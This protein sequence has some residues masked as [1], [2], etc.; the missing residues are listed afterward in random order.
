MSINVSQ[1]QVDQILHTHN[2]LW[3]ALYDRDS[4]DHFL[5]YNEKK[6]Q[7]FH[8]AHR[9]YSSVILPNAAGNTFLWI[10]Q[11]LNKSTY[12]THEIHNGRDKNQDIRITWVVDTRH[13]QFSYRS[14]IKTY[15]DLAGNLISGDIEYYTSFGTQVIWSTN[16]LYLTQK[17]KH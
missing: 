17:S 12:G 8:P 10:T 15:S 1:E 16:P 11:N 13:G 14:N 7:I 5:V 4:V 9:G 3:N 6:Y 2:S